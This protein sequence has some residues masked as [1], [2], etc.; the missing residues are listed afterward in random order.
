M[1]SRSE[2][3]A[4][5]FTLVLSGKRLVSTVENFTLLLEAIQWQTDHAA[6]VE[7][8]VASPPARSAIHAGIRLDVSPEFLNNHTSLFILYLSQPSVKNRCNGQFL[9]ELLELIFDPPTV[10]NAFM[11]AFQDELL[12]ERGMEA[13]AWLLIELLAHQSVGQI[14][15]VADAQNVADNGALLRS[16]SPETRRYGH[17]LQHILQIKASNMVVHNLDYFPGGRHDNDHA[18]FRRIAIYPTSSEFHSK[19]KPFYRRADE[20]LELAENTRPVMHLD[21]QF[22]LLR[23]DMLSEI[24]EEFL[25]AR[26][27]KQKRRTATLLEKL[28]LVNVFYGTDKRGSPCS[29]VI[30]CLGGLVQLTSR[31]RDARKAFLENEQSFLRHRS[32]G[33][34]I[35]GEEIVSFAMV[36]RQIDYLLKSPPSVVLRVIGDEAVR[37]TLSYFKLYDDIRF[38]LVDAPVFAYEP[39]LRQL[40]EKIEL[41]LAEELL[42]FQPVDVVAPS[43]TIPSTVIESLGD[44]ERTLQ[45]ILGTEKPLSLDPSQMESLLSGLTQRVSLIQGP[46]GTGKSF[47]GALI[48]KALYKH[49]KETILVMCYTNHALDQFLEDLM[50]I[51][52][53]ESAIVRLGSKSCQRTKPLRLSA[54]QAI[55]PRKSKATWSI[56]DGLKSK[57]RDISEELDMAFSAYSS[58]KLN[59]DTLQEYLEFEEPE[60]LEAFVPPRDPDGM[61]IVGRGKKPISSQ[62]LYDQW[63]YG[64]HHSLPSL[65]HLSAEARRVWEMDKAIRQEKIAYWKEKLLEEHVVNVQGLIARLDRCQKKLDEMWNERTRDVLLSKRIIGCTTTAAAINASVLNTTSPGVVLLEEAGEIL[66]SHVLTAL[67]SHTK[68]LIMIGDHQQLRPKINNYALSVEKGS[69]YDLNRSLFERLV[70]SGYPHST[71]AKQHRMAPE[72]SA[73]VRRLTYPDLLDGDKT[74]TRLAPRGLQNRVVFIDHSQ[75]EGFLHGV[76]DRDGDGG[77]GSKQNTFEVKLVLKI[78]KYLGQQGYGTDK[79]VILTPYLG[80][81]H[82]LREE[83]RKDTDPVLNDLDSYDLVRAGLI[84]HASAQHVKRPI[85]LSTIDNYQGE[86]S[87]IVI[88]TLTRSNKDGDIGF[89]SAPQRLNVLLSR[90]RDVLIMIGNS[91]TFTNSRKGK[92]VWKPFFDQLQTNGYLYDGLPVKCEQH[93]QRTA[94]LQTPEDFNKLCPDGGCDEPCGTKLNCGLHD[95]PHKCHQLSDH[96]KMN[97]RKVIDWTCT[98]D[99]RFKRPCFQQHES[100]HRCAEEDKERERRR[101]R[102]MDLELQSE[103]KRQEYARQLAQL[104]EEIAHERRLQKEDRDEQERQRILS[105]H[106]DDLQKMRFRAPE[107]FSVSP[108]ASKVRKSGPA[109]QGT[110]SQETVRQEPSHE[111][112]QAEPNRP[113]SANSPD[114]ETALS[115]AEQDWKYQKDYEG[116]E[117]DEL[118]K[119]MGM[120]GLE[121]SKTK[122]LSIKSKVDTALRQNVD[123]K[124]ERF[125]SVLLG[126]PGT[127]KTTVARLYAKFLTAMGII[128][129]SSIIETT[130]S[131]LANGGVSGCE[132]QINGILN[133]GGG[134]L[135]IDEA[136]Q[137]AQ[138]NGQGSQ[139]L[140]F[141]LAE[142][143]NLTGKVVVVLAGY[144]RQMEK[145]F[146]HNP[147]LPS[148]FPHEFVFEDYNEQE[149]RR[150]FE[151]RIKTKFGGR[152]KVAG[153]MGGLFCRIVARR[154]SKQRGHEGFGN[155]RTVENVLDRILERQA[156]RLAEERRNQTFSDDLL[157]TKED[158]IGPEPSN[159]LR[160]CSAWKKLQSM[161]GLTS[162]KATVKA[163]LD[164]MQ[165]NYERELNEK[166]LVEF[167]LNRVFLG[168]PGTGKTTVAKLYG[169]ILVDLGY[170]SNGEV[171]VKNPAD[172]IGSVIGGSEQNTKGILASTLGKVLVIDEAYG[173]YGGGTRD[174]ASSNSNQFKTAVIDTIVAEVQGVPGDDRCVLL[175]GYEEQMREMFQNVNPGLSRR[176]SPD[177]A[178]VFED[179]SDTELEQILELKVKEQGFVTSEKG[180]KVAMEILSRARNRP[181]FG[182]AGEIDIMLNGAKVRQQQ[183]RSSK[184]GILALDYFEPQDLDPEYDR[185]ERAETNIPMLFQDIVGCESIISKLEEYRQSVKNMRELDMD[186]KEHVPF[187][188]L[189]RGPPGSGKTSTARK[190]GKVYYDMGLLSSAEVIESSATDLIGQYIGHT[191]PKT[192]ELLEKS[193]G[194]VLLIDEAYRLAEGQFAKEAMDEMVDCIT[195]PKFFQKLIIILAGYDNDINRLMTINPGLTSRFPEELEFNGLAPAD[196]LQLL[197]K[198]LQRRKADFLPKVNSFDLDALDSP[199]SLFQKKLLNRFQSLIRTANWANARDIQ[200]LAKTI[201]RVAIQ[202][203]QNKNVSV[204]EELILRHVD[205]MISERT[206]REAKQ[207]ALRNPVADLLQAQSFGSTTAPPVLTTVSN[208]PTLHEEKKEEDPTALRSEN[209]SDVVPRDDGVADDVWHQ[210]QQDKKA[211]EAAEKQYQKLLREERAAENAVAELPDPPVEASEPDGEAKKQHERRRLEELKRRAEL[212]I[213]RKIREAEEQARRKEQQLQQKLRHMGRCVAGFQWIKQATGYRCAGGSHFVS[214]E[215]LGV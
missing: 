24:R 6:C 132:K 130:G 93:P 11:G 143:E 21:N 127:G 174:P 63:A 179:F 47:V 138:T 168:S 193:L 152:M 94:V 205:H 114:V 85:K 64:K 121:G 95:C 99:H 164:S 51:G 60:F 163:L 98:R 137:L 2:R 190:M 211:A 20:I 45:D 215:A 52:I 184:K 7:R 185:G 213:L 40:Q 31:D 125:G 5:F 123:L 209:C 102:D 92:E 43:G 23:E 66:E 13:F 186:P 35:R 111:A 18:D 119:L 199:S 50:D 86:E 159:A 156:K 72:I 189:F 207:S 135:F 82:L 105:Q 177:N 145:F 195:K 136:Y 100:C 73:L 171:I 146:A 210:L 34:L 67:G 17:K 204:T 180:K 178:F 48:A 74:K 9:Q 81:L 141:L 42:G 15:V 150:I 91:N 170:L 139:V 201:F 124:G 33:C 14:N 126:N 155:A 90:A 97:C 149:L 30:S 56:I 57:A 75:P 69:G 96:S 107:R 188:F 117:S 29:L 175:L 208:P 203:M 153:G 206:N 198:L 8:I 79:L 32:F 202:K 196:C 128:P 4:K 59:Y 169:Q 53:D 88:A 46:P 28:D 154:I 10:W 36:D 120:I 112:E 44:Q 70:E 49:S 158:L 148:R 157:L 212:E 27:K 58:F 89:M 71:L 76:S 165:S 61:T 187:N 197:T 176:F 22:R 104:Q 103:R 26:G 110:N 167:T 214:N 113:P 200:T 54:Q 16:L 62:Y 131:R 101:Q 129:G 84:S 151:Y 133:K 191:G 166:P 1:A 181:N 106:R 134:V 37:K 122:F 147:G 161:I 108:H 194:K 78:V 118:D 38:L 183:R 39:I 109:T 87:D 144:R 172:F 19:E 192:Q 140:D 77:K 162:V 160:N 41:P 65:S 142:I 182:N 115:S 116:A 173:L 80:Q 12:T 3:L 83:L 25:A 68:Q 55:R